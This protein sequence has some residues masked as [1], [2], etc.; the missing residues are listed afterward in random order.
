MRGES[1]AAL[2]E[3]IV[4]V[5]IL[6]TAGVAA[7]VLGADA[8]RATERARRTDEQVRAASAFMDAA[9]LWPR[10]DLA[11]RLG[12]RTQGPWHMRIDRP[13]PTLYTIS[14][15]DTTNGQELIRTAVFRPEAP[16]AEP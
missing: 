9:I 16:N 11:R 3:V 8:V 7:V 14:L 10:E 6:A 1:G 13:W 4:A 5:T 15:A 12:D 2:L